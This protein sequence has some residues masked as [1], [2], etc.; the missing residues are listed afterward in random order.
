[1]HYNNIL[2]NL[3][4]TIDNYSELFNYQGNLSV[5]VLED[6][7]DTF[8]VIIPDSFNKILNHF[9]KV[10]GTSYYMHQ[11]SIFEAL[12]YWIAESEQLK[13]ILSTLNIKSFNNR[14]ETDNFDH[15]VVL[16]HLITGLNIQ[17]NKI[18]ITLNS[19]K[20]KHISRSFVSNS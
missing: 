3:E 9:N 11:S 17:C 15:I 7:N 2:S 12:D 16:N 13:I 14:Q 8:N 4:K 5:N 1:M 6:I 20:N 10:N 18:V 19:A